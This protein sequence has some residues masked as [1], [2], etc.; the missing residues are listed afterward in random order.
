MSGVQVAVLL[1]NA[2]LSVVG[3]DAQ[4]R[5]E[6]LRRAELTPAQLAHP[7][8]RVSLEA[9]GKLWQAAVELTGDARLGLHVAEALEEGSF[10]TLEYIALHSATLREALEQIVRYARLLNDTLAYSLEDRGERTHFLENWP[11]A[12][13]ICPPHGTDLLFASVI[14]KLRRLRAGFAPREVRLMHTS[15]EAGRADYARVF[16]CPVLYGQAADEIVFDRASLDAPTE[17]ADAKLGSI[18]ARVADTQLRE[19]PDHGSLTRRVAQR[20]EKAIREGTDLELA[21]LAGDLRMTPRTL[22]RKLAEVPSSYQAV[23]EETRRR[24]AVE[25]LNAPE[26]DVERVAYRL[27]FADPSSFI[28]S[29]KRWFGTTPGKFRRAPEA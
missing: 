3:H 17:R 2:L 26:A 14:L 7:D 11:T 13:Q 20:L 9:L 29:F 16:G 5:A 24:L 1:P 6:L 10:G 12:I 27:G 8:A 18:L 22:Q 4:I 23:L 15:D 19:I 25:M 28:R 21:T